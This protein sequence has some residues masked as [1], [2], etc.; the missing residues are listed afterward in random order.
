MA[1]QT[2]VQVELYDLVLLFL[3]CLWNCLY[4]IR[5]D[6][7]FPWINLT[8]GDITL[9]HYNKRPWRPQWSCRS[10]LKVIF[11]ISD[12]KYIYYHVSLASKCLLQ[13]N[14]TNE[15]DQLSYV[16]WRRTPVIN[17]FLT[18]VNN[19]DCVVTESFTFISSRRSLMPLLM[20]MENLL[21]ILKLDAG[22][23]QY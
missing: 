5:I 19:A 21:L 3:L 6:S 14:Q 23:L 7:G 11:E 18:S 20:L 22:R 8:R 2:G 17:G 13:L 16:D 4:L 9:R 15:R 1:L 12:I 10:F